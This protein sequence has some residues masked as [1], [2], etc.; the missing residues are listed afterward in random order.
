MISELEPKTT[1]AAK[2]CFLIVS[3]ALLPECSRKPAEILRSCER[4]LFPNR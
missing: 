1:T 2:I 3:T 4:T